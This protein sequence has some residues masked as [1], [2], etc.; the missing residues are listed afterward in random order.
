MARAASSQHAG[1]SVNVKEEPTVKKEKSERDKGKQ[2]ARF[3]E[4]EDAD[5]DADG[6]EEDAA[7]AHDEDRNSEGEVDVDEEEGGSPRGTK[8][9]RLNEAGESRP[10]DKGKY[11]ERIKTLPR[12]VDGK[13]LSYSLGGL[14]NHVSLLVF[15]TSSVDVRTDPFQVLG[16]AAELNSF[17]KNN[18]DSGYIEIELKGRKGEGNLVIRRTLSATSKSSSFTLNG[19][20]AS[21]KEIANKMAELNVQV[22]NLCSFLPQDKVSEFAQMTPQQLLRETQRAA[23]DERLT[24]WHDTLI[25]A[26]KELK[27]LLQ[28]IKD[29]SDQLRQM[30]ERNEGIERDVQRYKE[31]K[32]IEATIALLEVLIP[33]E[34]Y[35]ELRIQFMEVK[36]RQRMLHAK[37]KRLKAK[38]EP[39]HALLKKLDTEHKEHDKTREEF[40]K[41]TVAKFNKMKAKWIASEKLEGDAEELTSRLDRLKRE[42]K[43]RARRIRALEIE[44]EKTKEEQA[45]LMEVKLEKHEDLVAE[46]RQIHLERQDVTARKGSV[47]EKLKTNIDNK[48]RVNTQLNLAHGELKKLDDVNVRKLQS[49][50]KWDMACHDAVLWL[51]KNRHLFKMEVFEPAVLTLNV[52][53]KRYVNAVEASFSSWQLRTFVCQCQEDSDT[54]NRHVNDEGALGR[55]VRVATWFRPQQ[56][57]PPPPMTEEEMVMLGFDGYIID[58]IDCPE[59]MRWWMQRELNLHRLAVTLNPNIDVNKAMELVARPETGGGATF[60]N[61]NTMN[62]VSRSRYGRR[63]IGNTTRD[64]PPAKSLGNVTIDPELKRRIDESIANFQQE[65]VSLEKE[66]AEL[67]VELSNILEEDKVFEKRLNDVKQRRNAVQKV[68]DARVKIAS[69]LSRNENTLASLKGQPSAEAERARVKRELFNITKKR[70]QIAKEYTGLA[71]SVIAEQTEATRIGIRYLQVAA[72]RAALQELC[73][74]KDEK[75]QTALAEF[76]RV[77]EEFQAIKRR[78]KEALENSRE[79]MNALDPELRERYNAIEAARSKYEKDLAKAEENGTTPPSAEGVDLRTLDELQADLETQR[80]NLDLN[81]NT[82]PGVVE[83][84][85]KR[86][87]D[88]EQLGKTI[89]EKQ[90]KAERIERN[91]QIARDNWQPALE[92]LV[93]SIGEKFSA[94]F[95]RIGCAGE[96]RIRQHED[97]EKWAIDILVKFRDTEK[98]QLLTGT[99]QS[100]GERSLT[101][102]L[103]LLSLTEEARAPFSLVDEIN[104]GMD[105]RAER[106]VHNSMVQVTCKEDSAQY[107]LITPKLLPDL[108]YHERMKI[109]CVNNGE[110]L[111]EERDLGNM[112]SMID[113][114]V[115]ARKK[116]PAAP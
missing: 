41:T 86:K 18:T 9:T 88:I 85:E 95:D 58:F 27:T 39:A 50:Y 29:E 47:D 109:L 77:D 38:N 40:K 76:D 67:D 65:I 36:K 44:I 98:L 28:S 72:N 35:R 73:N 92:K 84:Y 25:D 78:S 20:S 43:D 14:S 91:I 21:G 81:L 31:R 17:V 53:D 59:G 54:F 111:P 46:A 69:K 113:G 60:I 63:A 93:A 100:G 13:V 112:M 2:K 7:H 97:Y 94:S 1:S 114:Y 102:I 82:N 10:G 37:V 108:M 51:R 80:A 87:R 5:P 52:P 74:K 79:V 115:A 96:V 11:K 34:R 104:Q 3:N 90:K 107:F 106:S 110:W 30:E 19:R 71:R 48:A 103:Y 62:N 66:R 23:G 83:Q 33:I 89:E 56:K 49:L 16:R 26:G 61:G 22:G 42:E 101:T 15:H 75:Y 8:R 57:L 116:K 70:I 4:D 55:K 24:S 105:Q 45:K 64:V 32:N 99:R 68:E 12:D 6:E